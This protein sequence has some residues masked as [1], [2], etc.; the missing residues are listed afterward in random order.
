MIIPRT[1]RCGWWPF[2]TTPPQLRNDCRP[3]PRRRTWRDR[4]GQRDGDNVSR[5]H[6]VS[7]TVPERSAMRLA[8]S[9]A[10]YQLLAFNISGHWGPATIASRLSFRRVAAHVDT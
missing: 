2:T 9:A 1:P 8:A 5:G 7:G 10:V 3:K 4:E 6:A